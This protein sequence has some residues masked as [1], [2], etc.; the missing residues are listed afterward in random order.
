MSRDSR[1]PLGYLVTKV[2]QSSAAAF[3][4]AIAQLGIRP[5]HYGLLVAI[6]AAGPQPQQRLAEALGLVPSA[7]VAMV[8]DLERLGAVERTRQALD[9]RQVVVALTDTGAALLE[10][11]T[12]AGVESDAVVFAALNAPE[13]EALGA[14][15]HAVAADRGLMPG[16]Q[17]SANAPARDKSARARGRTRPGRAQSGE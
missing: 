13:R 14:A 4:E 7:I 1:P 3:A 2:G 8:D 16:A 15:L 12:A 10:R 6:D 11:A 9:R 5:K 17:P